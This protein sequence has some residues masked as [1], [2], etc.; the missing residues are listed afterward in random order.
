MNHS[1]RIIRNSDARGPYKE[2][3]KNFGMKMENSFVNA[4]QQI[5]VRIAPGRW[6]LNDL[7]FAG[8]RA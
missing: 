5:H 7:Y 3:L 2:A 6:L 1:Q 8:R 4:N